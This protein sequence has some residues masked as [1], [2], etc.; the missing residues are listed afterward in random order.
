MAEAQ[1]RS[2]AGSDGWEG[3]CAAPREPGG[4][5]G[6]DGAAG[7]CVWGSVSACASLRAL[8]RER[9]MLGIFLKSRLLSLP[10]PRRGRG[11]HGEISF[12]MCAQCPL[13][14]L[15]S[16]HLPFHPVPS[17]LPFLPPAE[18]SYLVLYPP[19]QKLFHPC[20]HS[21]LKLL[22]PPTL[23]L[24]FSS[25]LL[26]WVNH[27]YKKK[28]QRNRETPWFGCHPV[29]PLIFCLLLISLLSLLLLL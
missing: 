5:G 24:G 22:S 27:L 15:T 25:V 19:L 6:N 29:F 16:S 17:P 2:W 1:S 10:Q 28:R 8:G 14:L 21:F 26:L 23:S 7:T 3:H 12:P 11:R 18:W 9:E 4:G 20:L 13:C